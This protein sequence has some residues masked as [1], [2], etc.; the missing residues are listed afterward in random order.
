M[1]DKVV[2]VL[3]NN[4]WSVATFDKEP[5]VVPIHFREVLPDGRL[6]MGD[7]FMETTLNNIAANGLVAISAFDGTTAE[8]YQV[9]GTAEYVTEGEIVD[10][11][12]KAAE[13]MF[14]GALT[15]K[16]AVIVTP[17]KV[18]VTGPG[19]ENKKEI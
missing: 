2:N 3:K 19:P 12:K 7:V 16:G 13:A 10:A 18:I 9:K 14:G 1:N 6:A 11:F 17:T 4:T 5:N 8:G 15:A